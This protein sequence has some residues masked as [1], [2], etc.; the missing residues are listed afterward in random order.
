MAAVTVWM[1]RHH[2]GAEGADWRALA[3]ST[4]ASIAGRALWFYAR[5]ARLA[6]PPHVHLSA[7]DDRRGG[8]RGSTSSRS[9]RWRSLARAVRVPRAG[10]GRGPLVAVLF[11]AGTLVPA[12][13]FINVFPMRY[14]FV[15]DHFQ[16]LASA[17]SHRARRGARRA[18]SRTAP[19]RPAPRGSA[20]GA[21]SS[22]V[23]ALLTARQCEVYRDLRT[24]WTDTLAKNPGAWMAHN[25]LAVLLQGQDGELDAAIAHYTESLRLNPVHPEAY[26]N[27]GTARAAKG[28]LDAAV[29]AYE[30][31]L[32]LEPG[33]AGAHYNLGLALMMKGRGDSAIGHLREA[34]RLR[35]DHAEAHNSLGVALALQGKPDEAIDHFTQAL[36]FRSD[37]PEAHNNLGGALQQVGRLDEAIA[38]FAEAVRLRP[39]YDQAQDNLRTARAARDGGKPRP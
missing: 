19:A 2:V 9:P 25:N 30:T 28:E 31:A 36:R 33:M 4:A 27:L 32:R 5:Q 37:Y 29:E 35:P 10:S 14:S 15:A 26:V 13:G 7:L 22:S 24:L 1:E 17:R 3:R 16:Y 12:L 6:A 39:T 20:I 11:F 38:Q 18:R 21:P 34:S 23:L 8:L